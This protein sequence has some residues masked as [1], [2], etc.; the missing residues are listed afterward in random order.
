MLGQ[1]HKSLITFYRNV[2]SLLDHYLLEIF[3]EVIIS[4]GLESIERVR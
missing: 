1:Q 2:D 3:E 4:S